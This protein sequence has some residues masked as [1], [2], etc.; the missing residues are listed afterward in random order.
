MFAGEKPDLNVLRKFPAPVRDVNIM[1]K[2]AAHY[3][4]LGNILLNSPN[5]TRVTNIEMNV[6]HQ[7]DPE[8]F[9]Y[10]IF[11]KWIK[12][13]TSATWGKLVQ[14]LKD[15]NLDSLALKIESSL[16]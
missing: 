2:V 14:C 15:I 12:E 10:D 13:D 8:K 11:Q 6:S 3:R 4:E 1:Q 9:I 5:G 16:V 7:G